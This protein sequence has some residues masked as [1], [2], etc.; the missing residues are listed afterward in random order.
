MIRPLFSGALL[1]FSCMLLSCKSPIVGAECRPGFELCGDQCV[2]LRADFR[3][4]GACD[5]GCGRF[6]CEEGQCSTEALHD[7]GTDAAT[8]DPPDATAYTGSDAAADSGVLFEPDAGLP[9]CLIGELECASECVNPNTDARHCG[10]CGSACASGEVCSAGSCMAQCEL[11]LTL[12]NNRCFDLQ[13]EPE[14]C[15]RCGR[16]CTSGICELGVCA[17][18][19]AGQTVVIGHDFSNANNAMQ[20]LAGNAVFLAPGAPVR[21]LVYEGEADQASIAGVEAAI[22]V[23]KKETGRDWQRIVAIE[24]LVPLQLSAADVLLVHA[25]AGARKSTLTKLGLQWGN[26]MAQFV[27]LGGVIVLFDAPSS[28]NDGTYRVLEAA[29]IFAARSR[30]PIGVQ[31]LKVPDPGLGV[32]VRI[33]DRY[34]SAAQTVHFSGVTTPGTFVVVDKDALPVIIQRVIVTR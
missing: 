22:D 6:I 9:G 34:M 11:P 7:A 3:H 21:V 17:D 33:P 23:V 30:E 16:R 24:A 1:L 8:A 2:D 29:Q 19:I 32:A 12:C 27:A 18:A 20:R 13:Y 25:Q 26:A 4:C 31:Q 5:R 28:T 14:H 15:G 10:R